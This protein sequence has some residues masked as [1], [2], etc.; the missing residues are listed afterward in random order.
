MKNENNF[1]NVSAGAIGLSGVI[2]FS[3][4]S[5]FAKM[6][7]E[8]RVD[9]ISVLYLRMLFAFP[10]VLLVG[11]LYERTQKPKNIKWCD[12]LKVAGISVLGYYIS[13]L[14]NFVGLVY[15]EA[16]IERLILFLYPTMVIFLSAVF[17][18]KPVTAK[19]ILAISISYVGI[20]IAFADKL[21]VK[22]ST[23][24]WIGVAMVF[25]SSL[26]YAIFLT[27]SDKLIKK[28]GSVRFTTTATL[29]MCFCLI[30]H[31]F[32]SGKA[33]V[34]GYNPHVYWYCLLMA[35]LSTVIPVYMFNYSMSKLGATNLSIIS[36]LGPICTLVLS[37]ILLNETITIW[38][39]IGTFVVIAG[40]LIVNME[41]KPSLSW[42]L[43]KIRI[44][45]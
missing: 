34:E 32:F 2:M 17:L 44:K 11:F 18:K 13:A 35:V 30:V 22:N 33:G 7:F 8:Y 24:F 9:P 5:V 28:V 19:Q 20:F 6:A 15:I 36:C 31:A 27:V 4:K 21:I 38:Q 37:A 43:Q 40:I 23:T 25:V 12:I 3:A 1:Q 45:S 41:N 42:I 16:S 26:T 39:V 29:T 10:L 14:F